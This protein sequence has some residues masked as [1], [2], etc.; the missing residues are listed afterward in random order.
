LVGG[1]NDFLTVYGKPLY[2]INEMSGQPINLIRLGYP[3]IDTG[4]F[5][6][7]DFMMYNNVTTEFQDFIEGP[8][9]IILKFTG[10]RWLG[11]SKTALVVPHPTKNI[12]MDTSNF[13]HSCLTIPQP[14]RWSHAT[15]KVLLQ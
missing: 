1:S 13:P 5:T 2:V 10:L 8:Y 15:R 3:E 7:D 12:V 14:I 9:S 6:D 11:E 4:L